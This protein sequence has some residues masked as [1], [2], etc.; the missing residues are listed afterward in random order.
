[1][2][3]GDSMRLDALVAALASERKARERLEAVQAVTDVALAHLELEELL[4]AL[5]VRTRD[6]LGVDTCAA[7]LLD[8]E[9]NELVARAAVGIEEEVEEG[10]RIPVGGGFAG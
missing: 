7:L 10:V 8:E 2:V 4:Q 1:M 5:L 6:I 9:R 3:E